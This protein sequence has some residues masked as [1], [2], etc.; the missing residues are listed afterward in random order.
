MNKRQIITGV[1]TISSLFAFGCEMA[2][3]TAA[4]NAD[5]S[6]VAAMHSPYD[7]PGFKTEI[8]DGRLWVLKPGEEPSEKH[9]SLIGAGPVGM[10]IRALDKKTA[11][12]YLVAKPGFETEIEDGRLWVLKDGEEKDEKRISFIGAGPMGMT[13]YAQSKDTVIEYL[14][15]KPGFKTEVEDGRLWV[16]K[17]GEVP[18]EKHISLIGAGPLGVTLRA[19][20]KQTALEYLTAVPGF[21]TMIKD[22][23]LWVLRD[24]QKE[25]EKHITLIGAGPMGMTV[26]ALDRQ[27]ANAYLAAINN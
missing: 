27:T 12:E 25:S 20:D 2:Q 21:E 26:K 18:S 19:L 16:L 14:G 7:K 4:V 5:T 9:I 10:T 3:T 23:R 1:L 13:I 22:G 15:E 11:L 8:E 6:K 17:S 24:G